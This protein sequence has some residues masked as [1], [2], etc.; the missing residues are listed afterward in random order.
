MGTDTTLDFQGFLAWLQA[1][2]GQHMIVSLCLGDSH[3]PATSMSGY[4]AGA[5]DPGRAGIA[6]DG[7]LEDA[8]ALRLTREPGDPAGDANGRFLV[9]ASDFVEARWIPYGQDYMAVSL[10]D[11]RLEIR[12]A[13]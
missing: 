3:V 7:D 10:S 1:R 4:L 11:H 9:P 2:I 12:A 5:E 8:I 13:K 6:A